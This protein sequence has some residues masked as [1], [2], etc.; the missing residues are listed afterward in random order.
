MNKITKLLAVIYIATSLSACAIYKDNFSCENYK[1][2]G[3]SCQRVID[4]LKDSEE[5]EKNNTDKNINAKVITKDKIDQTYAKLVETINSDDSLSSKEKAE[6]LKE[7][8]VLKS[9][10]EK[11]Y[12]DKRKVLIEKAKD[13]TQMQVIIDKKTLEPYVTTPKVLKVTLFPYVEKNGNYISIRKQYI[14]AKEPKFIEADSKDIPTI[15]ISAQ[16]QSDFIEKDEAKRTERI[17]VNKVFERM[18]EQL[19]TQTPNQN[20]DNS[21]LNQNEQIVAQTSQ[22]LSSKIS[23]NSTQKNVAKEYIV[24]TSTKLNAREN[25]DRKSKIVA[26]FSKNAKLEMCNEQPS[27]KE[28][29]CIKLDEKRSAYISSK[30]TKKV[31]F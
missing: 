14:I 8:E 2:L 7:I 23:D 31:G 28:W 20:K 15:N 13:I 26:I 10:R 27:N 17:I 29:I 11:D 21:S 1:G 16:K 19:E 30:Y 6:L 12:D 25:P 22:I 3:S 24:I 5:S 18:K 4:N 9:K